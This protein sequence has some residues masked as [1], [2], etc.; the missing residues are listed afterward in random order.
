MVIYN[1]NKTESEAF[2]MKKL[3]TIIMVLSLVMAGNAFAVVELAPSTSNACTFDRTALLET[4]NEDLIIHISYAADEEYMEIIF[5]MQVDYSDDFAVTVTDPQ[6]NVHTAE[7]LRRDWTSLTVW[8]DGLTS[9]KEHIVTLTSLSAS[10]GET[11]PHY[12][13]PDVYSA[14]FITIPP[15]CV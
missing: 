7:I 14:T 6:G 15:C 1:Q 11:Y 2:I 3:L 4:A 9:L 8:V 12:A 13:Q 10:D 5:G